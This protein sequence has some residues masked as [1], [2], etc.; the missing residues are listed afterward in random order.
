MTPYSLAFYLDVVTTGTVLGARP[1]DSP[2][3]VTALLGPDFAENVQGGRTMWRD[4]GLTEFHWHRADTRQP[5]RGHHISLQVHRLARRDRT[6]P[7]PA[8]RA[9]YG[10]FA[11]RLR[12]DKLHRLLARRG[13][14]LLEVPQSPA[15][16]P[17][18]RSY[19]Q[20]A[21]GVLV[22]V[23]GGDVYRIEASVPY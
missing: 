12:F 9:R 19:R 10:R 2:E 11:P 23:A 8:L 15:N 22:T 7:D 21:S 1:T 13:V 18:Y 14:P 3:R 5:W 4:Y 16:A 6:I 20:P 17:R